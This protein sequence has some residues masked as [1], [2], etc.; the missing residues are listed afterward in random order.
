MRK[1]HF[2]FAFHN[3]YPIQKTPAQH[4][5]AKKECHKLGLLEFY[6]KEDLQASITR[7]DIVNTVYRI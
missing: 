4:V 7:S 3:K 5:A 1:K 6:I 2:F